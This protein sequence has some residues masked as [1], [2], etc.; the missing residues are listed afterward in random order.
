M[1]GHDDYYGITV[2]LNT[3][4]EVVTLGRSELFSPG[5][6]HVRNCS[7]AFDVRVGDHLDVLVVNLDKSLLCDYLRNL[8]GGEASEPPRFGP[9]LSLLS[10]SGSSLWRY[11]SFIW[12]ELGRGGAIG[13]SALIQQEL[14]NTLAAMLFHTLQEQAVDTRQRDAGRYPIALRVVED[15]IVAHLA[16]PVSVA[17]LAEVSGVSARTLFKAFHE[18]HGTGPIGFLK[19][20]RLEAVQRALLVADP[21]S[22]TVTEVAMDFG[23]F[24]L[25]QFSKDYR[26]AFQELPSETLRR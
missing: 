4:L 3:S 12:S 6:G 10:P 7:D 22:T 23:F 15:Y 16:D 9:R 2:P 11:L 18:R 5:E 19:A 25:G 1:W 8:E 14:E 20:R 21:H 26:H 24:H 17:D 13:E